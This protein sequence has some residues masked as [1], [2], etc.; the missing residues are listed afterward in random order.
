MAPAWLATVLS[1]GIAS[2]NSALTRITDLASFPPRRA[3]TTGAGRPVARSTQ[4]SRAA[5]CFAE[6]T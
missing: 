1:A 5:A 4:Y 6:S 2:S 3:R